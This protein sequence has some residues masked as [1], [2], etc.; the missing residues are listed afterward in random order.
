MA[1]S[2]SHGDRLPE[3]STTMNTTEVTS[4]RAV[5][6]VFMCVVVAIVG[7]LGLAPPGVAADVLNPRESTGGSG[8]G[9]GSADDSQ[10]AFAVHPNFRSIQLIESKEAPVEVAQPP[11][12]T[13]PH[14]ICVSCVTAV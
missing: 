3:R 7:I 14:A 2:V 10:P 4:K 9:G 5:R 12:L 6:L 13:G 11:S 1:S 8:G